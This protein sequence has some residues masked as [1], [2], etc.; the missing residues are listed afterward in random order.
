[1][2]RLIQ[3]CTL[4]LAVLFQAALLLPGPEHAA[5]CEAAES[6]VDVALH[7]VGTEASEDG[8]SERTSGEDAADENALSGADPLRAWLSNS[9]SHNWIKGL[10]RGR[11]E[12][13]ALLEPPRRS[14]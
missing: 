11:S 8:A 9:A 5:R 4:L 13:N 6:T 7:A 1:M 10:G 3:I 2:P 12:V 14:T